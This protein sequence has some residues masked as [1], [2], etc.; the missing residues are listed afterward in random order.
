MESDA[1][2]ALVGAGLLILLLLLGGALYWLRGGSGPEVQRYV[3][4]F[5][6]QSLDGLQLNSPVRMQGIKVGKVTDYVILPNQARTVRVLIEVDARTPVLEGVQA[7]VA[8]NLVTGLAA[9]S[10]NN[11]GDGGAPLRTVPTGERY[12]VIA[13]G[14]ADMA[15]LARTV[16]GLGQ[17]GQEALDRINRLLSDG[18]Q[19]AIASSLHEFAGMAEELRRDVG[20]LTPELVATLQASRH[21]AHK[22]EVLGEEL[23]PVVRAGGAVVQHAGQ[24]LDSLAGEAEA[25]LRAARA[26]LG[27]LD[28][29]LRG[30]RMDLR[31]SAD[32]GLQEIQHTAQ[33]MRAASES[34]QTT[35]RDFADPGRILFGPNR[36]ELGPG[37][38]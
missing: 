38:R 11:P 9:V 17:S 20:T 22:L 5:Q 15:R 7:V 36:G 10:L 23:L 35:S 12:P 37:E 32:L 34:L 31:L 13:E 19:R 3:V 16:E 21:A 1:R 18:N 27:S 26:T 33:A 8:R 6:N 30:L 2:Y 4:Y 28:A 29:G 25:A 14:E 24:R